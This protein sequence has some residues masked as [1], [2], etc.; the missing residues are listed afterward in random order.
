M[1]GTTTPSPQASDGL[2]ERARKLGL[3]GLVASWSAVAGQP[4]LERLVKMEEDERHRRS[5]DRRIKR[6]NLGRFK[7][8][9][10]FD[11]NW[12]TKIDREQIDEL[13]TLGFLDENINPIFV[14]PNGVGKTMISENLAYAAVLAGHTV[15]VTTASK[16]LNELGAPDSSVSFERRL[17]KY[18]QP[19]LLAIDELGYLSYDSRSADLLFEIVTRRYQEKSTIISTNRAFGEW[20]E[21]FPNASCVVTLIDRLIHKSEIVEIEGES[22]RRKEAL[23]RAEER[24]KARRTRRRS[25]GARIKEDAKKEVSSGSRTA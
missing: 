10:D 5:H 9:A 2:R 4:W 18:T 12:P 22:Y 23:E 17:R 7:P 6:A 16:L 21:T 3:Y 1:V 15:H 25:K 13:F 8:I 20:N 24:A 11:W 19:R 14:G